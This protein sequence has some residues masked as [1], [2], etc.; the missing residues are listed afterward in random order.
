MP[1]GFFLL[2]RNFISMIKFYISF[3]CCCLLKIT[4]IV[5]FVMFVY[6][7]VIYGKLCNFDCLEV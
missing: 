5:L 1:I 7:V 2:Y 3:F 4:G 6:Q